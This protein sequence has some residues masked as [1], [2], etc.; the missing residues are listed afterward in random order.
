MARAAKKPDPQ[1]A[2]DE[3][4]R[5]LRRKFLRSQDICEAARKEW[6]TD[7]DYY[8]GKQWTAKEVQVLKRRK[9]PA[10]VF[11]EVKPAVNGIIG[12]VE[13]G[14]TDPRAM[15]RTPQHADAA[16]VVTD[17][18]RYVADQTRFQPKRMQALR[19]KLVPGVCV[20]VVEVGDDREVEFR[21]GW[22]EEFFY[23][24]HS[25]SGDF[26]DARYLG[27]AKWM[28]EEDALA[29]T[30]DAEVKKSISAAISGNGLFVNDTHEDRPR[31]EASWS[32]ADSKLR[33]IMVIEMYH[34][35]GAEWRKCVFV[36]GA[37][38]ENGPSPYR[39]DRGRPYCN[40]IAQSCYVDKDNQRYGIVRAMRGPQ[41]ATNK[42][43]SKL[44]HILNVSKLRVSKRVGDVDE[45][46]AE[47]AKPDGIIQA[48]E[49]EVEELGDKQ[50]APAHV[51]LLQFA[52]TK[53]RRV[54][55][56]PG[57]VGRNNQSQ[58]GRAILAEQQ[59]GLA[60]YALLLGQFEDWTLRVYRAMWYCARQFWDQPKF[61]RITDDE[62]SPRYVVLNQPFQDPKTGQMRL[63]EPAQLDMDIVIDSA[64][65]TAVI[66]QE[67]YKDLVDLTS[68]AIQSGAVDKA[69]KLF[70]A[71]IEASSLYRKKQVLDKL[72]ENSEPSPQE[73]MQQELQMRGAVAEVSETEAS[74][75]LK[76]AQAVKAQQEAQM[77][78][79]EPQIRMA[80]HQGEM[81]MQREEFGQ[82]MAMKREEHGMKLQ[83]QA[84]AGE[85]KAVQGIQALQLREQQARQAASQKQNTARKSA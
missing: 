65:D 67:Q 56:S 7:R 33:R 21:K 35:N 50:L 2:Q 68:M 63:I 74:A 52:D 59:A 77:A 6:E 5:D 62:N 61:V 30:D 27:L 15:G 10:L 45:V 39:D 55:P 70:E 37:I 60:E 19:D 71:V 75:Q 41:D 25:R 13:R 83:Q 36:S 80:E 72:R 76:Q 16:D 51:E 1:A 82:N 69:G 28:D 3:Y 22:P 84:Q 43:W 79:V 73:Q 31:K 64:P 46:R 49:G 53:M 40:L 17:S 34:R 20:G 4:L 11:E 44:V 47:Y 78:G 24:P 29:L 23:D 85:M 18:L 66:Q 48:E 32:W 57:I 58:S 14:K 38:I 9:Q 42:G 54:S 8:D 26:S 12:V 81:Q